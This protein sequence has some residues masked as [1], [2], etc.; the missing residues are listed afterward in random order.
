MSKFVSLLTE[1]IL[2]GFPWNKTLVIAAANQNTEKNHKEVI[3]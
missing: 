1:G 2:I 3:E